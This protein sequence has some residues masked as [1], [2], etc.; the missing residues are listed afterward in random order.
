M[1]TPPAD[2]RNQAFESLSPGVFRASTIVFD[3]YEDFVARKT[4]QPDGFS[5][6]VTGTPTHRELEGRIAALEGANHCVVVPSG[7]AAL[8]SAIMP[9]VKSGDHILIS[10]ACYGGLKAFAGDW[11]ARLGV[12]V[13]VYPADIGS[14]IASYIMPSTRMIC[15][16]SPG[17]CRWKCPMYRKFPPRHGGAAFSP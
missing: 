16:E 13:D 2:Y 1:S 14:D 10:D 6:G 11:L 12:D 8:V 7:Q 4:R 15:L 3:S 17:R 9:F 5:Y